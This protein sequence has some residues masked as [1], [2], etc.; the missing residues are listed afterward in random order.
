[1][2]L[3]EYPNGRTL[4][5]QSIYYFSNATSEQASCT[6][7]PGAGRHFFTKNDQQTCPSSYSIGQ[8]PGWLGRRVRGVVP[9]N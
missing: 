9:D 8:P 4:L 5:R 3:L 2:V 6:R 7:G 1:M